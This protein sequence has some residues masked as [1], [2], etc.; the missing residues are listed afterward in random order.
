MATHK[1]P[2]RV[3]LVEDSPSD[4]YLL[5]QM[6]NDE[7]NGEFKY[8]FHDVPRLI[9]AFSVLDRLSFDVV[10]LDL[11]LVDMD[12]VSSI[13][14]LHKEK[15]SLPIIVYSGMDDSK[16]KEKAL[17]LGAHHYLVK[18]RES[19]YSLNF[20]IEQTIERARLAH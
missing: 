17:M 8:H 18:G 9:D 12:G 19:S 7:R 2:I 14:A 1:N 5:E 16:V 15:P 3:L 6:L 11:N 4:V 20:M 13:A 10:L